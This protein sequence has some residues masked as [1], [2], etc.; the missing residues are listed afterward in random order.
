MAVSRAAAFSTCRS[1]NYAGKVPAQKPATVSEDLSEV[2]G[3]SSLFGPGGKP[4]SV[5]TDLEQATG[6]ERLELLGKLK[7]VEVFDNSP[8]DA[9]RRGTMKDPVYVDSYD[10]ERY[11]GCTG[12]PAGSH[13]VMWLRPTTE[14]PARCWECGSVYA[15]NYLG[16]DGES[17]S[18]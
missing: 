17:H 15:I 18:H 10:H 4:Q 13:E 11:L 9:S 16:V 5:P 7:G 12:S 2:D 6:L 3:P 14:K 1:F 8:L